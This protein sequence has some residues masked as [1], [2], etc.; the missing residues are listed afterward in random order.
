MEALPFRLHLPR[1]AGTD[2]IYDD[3]EQMAGE[4]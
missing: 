1:R 2:S 3:Q 4:R